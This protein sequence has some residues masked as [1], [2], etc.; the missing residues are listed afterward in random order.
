MVSV[1]CA[2]A[3]IIVGVVSLT[4][5]GLHFSSQVLKLSLNIKLIAILLIGLTSLVLGMGLPVTASYIV[6]VTLAG[7]AL[8]K[9]GVPIIVTHMVV[10]WYSQFANVTPPVALASFA[11]AG[12]AGGNPMQTA[13]SSCKFA[14]GLYVIPLVM[15]YRPLLGGAAWWEVLIAMIS[16]AAG[17]V[18]FAVTLDRYLIRRTSLVETAAFLASSL[19]LFW[20]PSVAPGLFPTRYG[21]GIAGVLLFAAAF[22]SQYRRR[23]K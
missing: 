12:V 15:A 21:A 1:A 23:S 5:Q 22:F 10:F 3:G 8:L 20:P 16:T 17:L 14:V 4:G 13:F 6:L 7:P 18:A 2:A 19:L 9:I 11:G